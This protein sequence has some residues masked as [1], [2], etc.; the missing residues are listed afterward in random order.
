MSLAEDQIPPFPDDEIPVR[1][2]GWRRVIR[3]GKGKIV[4]QDP[5]TGRIVWLQEFNGQVIDG[6]EGRPDPI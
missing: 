4:L 1:F 2:P 5:A 6:A 3:T